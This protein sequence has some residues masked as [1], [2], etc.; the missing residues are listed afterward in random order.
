MSTRI[1][2]QA[3][4]TKMMC[5]DPLERIDSFE[6]V[7]LGYT[8]QDALN[9]ANRCLNC[10]NAMCKNGCPVGVDI[11]EFIEQIKLNDLQKA[12]EI[13]TKNNNFPS[14]CGRVCPQ[15]MQCE[16]KCVRGIKSESVAIGRLERYVADHGKKNSLQISKTNHK[17][18]VIGSGP[19][20]LSC[21]ADLIKHHI[22][23][24]VFEALHEFGGVLT[25]G[26]PEFRLPKNI[27]KT[28]I[29]HLKKSGVLFHQNI[30]VG[31][32]ISID[33]LFSEGFEAVFLA[34]GAGLPIFMNIKNE[35]AKG[36]FSANEFLTRI[37][38][39]KA[40]TDNFMTP[41]YPSMHTVVVGG[42]NVAMDAAR[43][44]RRLN[45]KVSILYRRGIDELP[46]RKE[47]VEHAM[48]EGIDFHFLTSPIE[49]LVDD[50]N[51][52]IGVECI[53]MNLIDRTDGDRRQ[54]EEI[55]GS[56][57]KFDCDCVIM[58]LGTTSN[59][60]LKDNEPKLIFNNRGNIFVDDSLK[61]SIDHVYAGGDAATGAATVILAMGAGKKAA[62]SILRELCVEPTNM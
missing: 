53:K 22:Q 39:M 1:N 38:L 6:E 56:N 17:V 5:L 16:K 50:Q 4:K 34:T 44:A 41:L 43:C 60:T 58:A 59:P 25:Y 45:R 9:E 54:I 46:A 10:K 24:E 32:T 27:V 33:E 12:F 2:N 30:V 15:E 20:G 14:I 51:K 31:K 37:N 23:V 7:A 19:A 52:V 3:E 18:A 62:Q 28:E 11:P 35:N 29:D 8:D 57:F 21:A 48:E 40:N 26:I 42:G 36:V 55:K 61:T 13:I 47:E 49:V